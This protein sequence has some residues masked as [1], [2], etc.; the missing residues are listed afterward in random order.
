MTVTE[1]Q[2]EAERIRPALTI[3]A[4]SYMGDDDEAEDVVQDVLL[5]LWSIHTD[6]SIP[7]DGY[8]KVITRNLCVDRLRRRHRTEDI[9]T[10][11]L[12]EAPATDT[13]QERIDRMMRVISTLPDLQ[14]TILQMRHING[15]EMKEI[16]QLVGSTEVAIRKT[17][18]RARQAV[19]DHY[20]KMYRS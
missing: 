14:Q 15:M 1:Y 9:A 10:L 16:A 7:M 5:K 8:A 17:L 6:V 19:R 12:S 18:S 2:H 11:A 13:D 20:L 3:A 4:R